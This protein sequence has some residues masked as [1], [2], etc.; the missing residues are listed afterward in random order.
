M[1]IAILQ[2]PGNV[3]TDKTFDRCFNSNRH[4]CGFAYIDP[5]SK[6]VKIEKGFFDLRAAR[7]RYHKLIDGFGG[8]DF[9]MLIHF[10]AATVGQHGYDNCHPFAVKGGAMIHNGTFF[11]DHNAIKSDSKQ[12]AEVMHNELTY[13]NLTKHKEHFQEAFGY[14]RVAFLFDEG[15]YVI[16]SENY[17]EGKNYGRLGQ[18]CD[19]IWY[20]NG[21]YAGDYGG[22]YGDNENLRKVHAIS[23]AEDEEEMARLDRQIWSVHK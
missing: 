19:G 7:E 23:E 17:H 5:T 15:K 11:R 22:Y 16:I 3:V 4:G 18:W 8:R 13:D 21:G 1:C 6:K 12:V 2:L 14:N 10:R 9:P 20:S